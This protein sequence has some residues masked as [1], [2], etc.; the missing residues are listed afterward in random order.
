MPAKGDSYAPETKQNPL[1]FSGVAGTLTDGTL[2]GGGH[3]VAGKRLDLKIRGHL[4]GGVHSP[5]G[6]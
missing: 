6:N 3:S 5:Y 4:F 1:T 2:A